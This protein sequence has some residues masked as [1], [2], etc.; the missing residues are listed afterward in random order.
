MLIGDILRRQAAPTGRPHKAALLYHGQAVTFASLDA[1]VNRLAHALL[2]RG[3]RR[4]DRVALLGRNSPEWVV[5]Y[6]AAAKCGAILVPV[7]FWYRAGELAYVL[8]DSSATVCLLS[9][10][11]APLA[12][13][14]RAEEGVLVEQWIWLDG[15]PSAAEFPACAGDPTLDDVIRD[16]PASEPV[17]PGGPLSETEPHIILYTSGTT[18]FPKGAMLS[19]R[20]HVQHAATFA[21]HT[22]AVEDDV[23]LNVY[24]L[25][26]TGGT[27][28]AVLP[29]HYV[30][31]TVAL[32]PDPKPDAVL[33]ALE[34]YG[35]TAMMAVPT[36]WRRLVEHPSLPGRDL[37]RFRRAM[38]SS[39]AM[40]L[41]LLRQVVDTFA[42][43][44]TQTYGLTEAGCILTYLPPADHIRK[45]GSVGKPHTQA[46]LIVADPSRDAEPD[47]PL[48]DIH[49]MPLGET[50]EVVARTEHV[51]TG[52]W[53]KPDQTA[54]ALRNGWLRTGDLGRL[55]EEGYLSIVGRL[56]DVIVSGGEKIYPAEV[57]PV[58]AQYPGVQELALV[59]VPDHEWGESI[60]AVIVPQADTPVDPATFKEWARQRV[61]GYKTPKHVIF[62]QS[63]PRT[64]GTG[65]IQKSVLREQFRS[66]SE[67]P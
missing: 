26:H 10:A 45:V 42:A 59:G 23:Y 36:I 55:D 49:Q 43:S 9:A 6:Y 41:D 64:T 40:P 8:L 67:K 13:A 24:P 35:V 46:D 61:A 44:W 37:S 63:L 14:V 47:W 33:E 16:M 21:L 12:T 17:L 3:L 62:L 1:Q 57:E 39:D 2:A 19:H 56:K 29:Y 5:A 58:L 20:A 4:G 53:G 15:R 11:F 7:N 22:G 30:G 50:G 52:Y 54:A 34:A 25:F 60:L 31:A 48:R 51:M 18:G 27:D 66:L 65:K 38:G 28:C 32:L